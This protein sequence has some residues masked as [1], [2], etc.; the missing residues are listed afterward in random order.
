MT[1]QNDPM[2]FK[3]D[4]RTEFKDAEKMDKDRAREEAEAL[5]EGIDYHDY[6]YYVKNDPVV[7]DQVYDALFRRLQELEAAFPDLKTDTSPTQR[8]G[9]DPMDAL[10]KIDHAA[11]MLSLNAVREKDE[12][13]D[14]HDFVGRRVNGKEIVYVLEPKLDGLSVEIVYEGGEFTYGATR[15]NGETG[16]GI[17]KNLKTIG[18]VPLR[19]R[20]GEAVPDYLSVRGEV[21]M[22]RAGFQQLNQRRIESGKDA[23]ANPRN[24]A[25]GTMRQL[26]PKNVENKP[27]DI[28]FYDALK[29]EGVE[30]A[31]HWDLLKRFSDWGL[32][33]VPEVKRADSLDAVTDYHRR[34]SEKRDDLDYEIDGIVI[35]IND[36]DQRET[37]GTRHR[38]PRWAVAWKFP[39]RREETVLEK[40]VVQVGRTGK[41]TPVALLRPVDVGG[42]TVSRASLHNADEV[43]KKDVRPGDKVRVAR[44]GDVIPEVVERIEQLGKKREDPFS[45]PDHC[46]ACGSEIYREG[47]Y[48][49]CPAGLSCRPQLIGGIIHYGSRDA[50]DIEGLGEKTA[51]DLVDKELVGDIADLYRL[52]KDDFL[53]LDGF[54][55]KS[56]GQLYEAVQDAKNPG[57]DRFLYA[58]GIRHVGQRVAG[59]LARRYRR[60]SDI[61]KAEADDIQKTEEIGPEIAQSVARFFRESVNRDVLDRIQSAGVEVREMPGEDDAPPLEGKTFVFTGSLGDYTRSEARERVE[62][63]GGRAT[64]SVSGNTD[65]V[66]VGEGPG[67]KRDEAGEKGVKIIDEAAFKSLIRAP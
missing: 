16:E 39:A 29:M 43:R 3:T 40:I 31:D 12:V 19:L 47:A 52:T 49:V 26:D 41:L 13:A 1:R 2:N 21:F 27:L 56:A 38:S 62:A 18:S 53:K 42:V 36:Y 17:S 46:P 51:E 64:S 8:V 23:F 10:E 66:V 48:H 59:I 45:M 32:K 28:F 30:V 65:Y 61:R 67:S 37:L 15:G 11:P 9:A 63:L 44:A 57:L 6:R 60:L 20:G 54:A 14:F 22:S 34:L 7:S 35:K 50:M 5:R 58:L 4:P 55:D 33:T 24:A 25:A